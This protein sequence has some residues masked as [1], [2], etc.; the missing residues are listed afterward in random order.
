MALHLEYRPY[1][2]VVIARVF[3]ARGSSKAA[4][5]MTS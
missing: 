3:S 4:A 2:R 1:S 5:A